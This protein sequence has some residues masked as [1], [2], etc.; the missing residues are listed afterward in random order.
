MK[1]KAECLFCKETIEGERDY[2]LRG[3]GLRMDGRR[4]PKWLKELP[5][6][7]WARNGLYFYILEKRVEFIFYLCPKHTGDKDYEAAFKWAH[8]QIEGQKALAKLVV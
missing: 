6:F 5:E 1:V 3:T 8:E 7:Q 2:M 4:R